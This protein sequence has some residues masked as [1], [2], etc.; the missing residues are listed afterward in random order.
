MQDIFVTHDWRDHDERT[1]ALA[2]LDEAFG[3]D[4]RN[5]GTPW[6]DPALKISSEEGAAIIRKSMEDQVRGTRIVLFL[7]GIYSGS[8]RGKTWVGYALEIA[9]RLSLPVIGLEF[10]GTPPPE[11][12]ALAD[13]WVRASSGELRH[14]IVMP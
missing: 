1:R 9:R 8:L 14:A 2:L 7:P 10:S 13:R 5:F 6:Y 11:T 12:Q 4:W 3:L